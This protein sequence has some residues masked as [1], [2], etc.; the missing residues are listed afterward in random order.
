MA[1][2][3]P[4]QRPGSPASP[5]YLPT[6]SAD[7][8]KYLK[9]PT[10]T[11]VLGLIISNIHFCTRKFDSHHQM[12]AGIPVYRVT[13]SYLAEQIGCSVPTISKCIKLLMER[14]LIMDIKN[15]NQQ[16]FNQYGFVHDHC[17][18]ATDFCLRYYFDIKRAIDAWMEAHPTG[19]WTRKAKSREDEAV[20][21]EVAN[22]EELRAAQALLQYKDAPA[23]KQKPKFSGVPEPQISAAAPLESD[24]EADT[25]DEDYEEDPEEFEGQ[26]PEEVEEEYEEQE[27]EP[28]EEAEEVAYG[29]ITNWQIQGPDDGLPF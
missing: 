7:I 29:N 13:E 16:I 27:P 11:M 14:G 4:N 6:C 18:C 26:E 2:Q 5:V 28:D 12:Y 17:L 21:E 1:K 8:Y 9:N 3:N 22:P 25:E 23:P 10:A 20:Q 19:F 15:G 24:Q